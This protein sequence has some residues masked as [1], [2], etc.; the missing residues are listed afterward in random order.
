MILEVDHFVK[1]PGSLRVLK[2][3]LRVRKK[4]VKQGKPRIL[5]VHVRSGK[6]LLSR[7]HGK[8]IDVSARR[9]SID[10]DSE[11]QPHLMRSHETK[12]LPVV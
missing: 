12:T 8:L 2:R 1:A 3:P 9:L 11:T 6:H 5:S 7:L 10:V 4:I